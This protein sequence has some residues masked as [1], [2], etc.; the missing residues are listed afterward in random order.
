MP[1][2]SS[3]TYMRGMARPLATAISSA[4]FSRRRRSGSAV[5]GSTQRAPARRA[6]T[7][8]PSPSCHIRR[9]VAAPISAS[10]TALVQP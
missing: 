5:S 1:G 6:T 7:G 4:T 2:S 8:P 10:V 9:S 3:I